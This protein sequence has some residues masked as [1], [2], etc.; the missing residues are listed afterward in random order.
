ML[1]S[2]NFINLVCKSC[3]IQINPIIYSKFKPIDIYYCIVQALILCLKPLRDYPNDLNR[4]FDL[5]LKYK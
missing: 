1:N 4:S 5:N 3:H 2:L